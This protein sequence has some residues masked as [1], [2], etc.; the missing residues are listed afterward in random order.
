MA[1]QRG[2]AK[3]NRGEQ[4]SMWWIFAPL[5]GMLL[6]VFG[7]IALTDNEQTPERPCTGEIEQYL[8]SVFI[9]ANNFSPWAITSI[10]KDE[11]GRP[12]A[13]LENGVKL[14]IGSEVP[15]KQGLPIGIVRDIQAA[16][17]FGPVHIVYC[18][19]K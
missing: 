18:Q 19:Y 11:V 15:S 1:K 12:Y 5:M 17:E 9:N 14:F 3:T 2:K 7:A 16:D 8:G 6:L 13:I 4:M 10:Q